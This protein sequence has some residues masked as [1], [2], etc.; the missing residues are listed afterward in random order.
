MDEQV[1]EDE[2]FAL[3]IADPPWVRSEHIAEHQ[4][5]PDHAI[6]G[7]SDGLDLARTCLRIIATHLAD[8]GSA[9]LQ[10]GDLE[11]V[12]AVSDHLADQPDLGLRLMEHRTYESRGVL[13]LLVR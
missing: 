7:G 1:G 4:D 6:D 11:Q 5:D 12:A 9:I 3:I 8:G 2:R 10:L 13:V